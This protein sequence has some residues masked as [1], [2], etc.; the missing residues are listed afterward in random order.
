M[1]FWFFGLLLSEFSSSSS[2]SLIFY[3][4]SAHYFS[5]IFFCLTVGVHEAAMSSLRCECWSCREKTEAPAFSRIL[6]ILAPS[7]GYFL[8]GYFFFGFSFDISVRFANFGRF[9]KWVLVASLNGVLFS[10]SSI[11]LIPVK[12]LYQSHA[13]LYLDKIIFSWIIPRENFP[14]HGHTDRVNQRK[15]VEFRHPYHLP[16]VSRNTR[17]TPSQ[18]LSRQHYIYKLS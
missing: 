12:P 2:S 8:S 9:L 16:S 10:T 6:Y 15:L 14:F 13:L 1:A 17:R 7:S 4:S 5:M 18:N 11:T 3:S